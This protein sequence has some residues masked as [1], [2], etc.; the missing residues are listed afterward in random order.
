[1]TPHELRDLDVAIAKLLGWTEVEVDAAGRWDFYRGRPPLVTWDEGRTIPLPYWAVSNAAAADLLDE[2]GK[3]GG[4]VMTRN[5]YTYGVELR[6]YPGY[7]CVIVR[8]STNDSHGVSSM[9]NW[10][11]THPAPFAEA[12]AVAAKAF[13]EAMNKRKEDN[14][15]YNADA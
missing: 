11:H 6:Q 3:W 8:E 1:M 2:I 13:L 15:T 4:C 5:F 9:Q 7:V 10:N 12:V 14:A